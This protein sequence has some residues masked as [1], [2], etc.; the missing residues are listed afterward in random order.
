MT[1][2]TK[3][4]AK[5]ALTKTQKAQI[6]KRWKDGER[7]KSALA[8][9]FGT[10]ARTVGRLVKDIKLPESARSAKEKAKKAKKV[11]LEATVKPVAKTVKENIFKL[12][13]ILVGKNSSEYVYTTDK[14]TMEVTKVYDERHISVEILTQSDYPS[15]VGETYSVLSEHFEKIGSISDK[16]TEKES[17][18]ELEIAEAE[19]LKTEDLTRERAEVGMAVVIKDN[20][21]EFELHVDEM[22]KF[23]N[24]EGT[25]I[26]LDDEDAEVRTEDGNYWYFRY[27][28]LA[29]F[30]EKPEHK[31]KLGDKVV[32]NDKA[33]SRYGITQQ[34]WTGKVVQLH[35]DKDCFFHDAN[36]K[37][38]GQDG[39][40]NL[41]TDYFELAE[42]LPEQPTNVAHIITDNAITLVVDGNIQLI[43]YT[44][45]SFEAV[46]AKIADG[47]FLEA[48]TLMDI[49]KCIE[50][51]SEGNLKI[52][53][54]KVLYR[55]VE[56]H[57]GLT[58]KIIDLMKEGDEGF[59]GF[60]KFFA[61]V[62]ENPSKQTR[63]RLMEFAA[64][65][66]IGIST[67]GDLVCFKNVRNDFKPSR[68]GAWV[69]TDGEWSYNK[70]ALY[71]NNVGDVCEMPRS[72]VED[73]EEI[74][75]AVGL[76]V[77][78]VHYLKAMWGTQGQTMK[79]HVHPA[80]FV[81]IPTD[82]NNSKARV[83]KYTVVE[84]VTNDLDKY[85]N[86]VS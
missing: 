39:V 4:T 31:F 70:D 29:T 48:S 84:N 50:H 37:V 33:T 24:T 69:Q 15:S 61:K 30:V 17:S 32:G 79:V 49:K 60:A 44:H 18:E 51:Y 22:H 57:N 56:V 58:A 45:P 74:T 67:E 5:A 34:G 64:A 46:K 23:V 62:M 7:N 16:E 27:E 71:T 76:H 21:E 78:S 52:E 12:G 55:G 53:Q 19:V 8:R 63:E 13:D 59:K 1:K 10:S 28:S 83:C 82:Y 11:A 43:D 26:A 9:E 73:R 68:S 25:I 47:D 35:K 66:D 75:C 2:T 85:L 77:C 80:D 14:A 36:F 65:E 86:K 40:F 42:E 41:C 81:A 3:K 54:E 38:E 72:E 20:L 6:V